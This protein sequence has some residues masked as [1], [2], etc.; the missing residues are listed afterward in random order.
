M[1]NLK[2]RAEKEWEEKKKFHKGQAKEK[3]KK[4]AEELKRL[5]KNI[6]EID[7]I[8]ISSPTVEID[9]I[10]FR[11]HDAPNKGLAM[12]FTCE[13]CHPSNYQMNWER[14]TCLSDVGCLLE[15]MENHKCSSFPK[16]VEQEKTAEERLVEAIKEIIAK[17]Q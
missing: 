13:K 1:M 11:V 4:N 15:R 10:K 12:Y 16:E 2:E 3:D 14:I 6:L 17:G 9:G 5:L 8:E 7:D